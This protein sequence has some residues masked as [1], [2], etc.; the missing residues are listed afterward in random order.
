M[1]INESNNSL[2]GSFRSITVEN[3]SFLLC[4]ETPDDRR[5]TALY[6]LSETIHALDS[7]TGKHNASTYRRNGSG[8]HGSFKPDAGRS[9]EPAG[10]CVTWGADVCVAVIVECVASPPLSRE[11]HCDL[12]VVLRPEM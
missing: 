6:A 9:V 4:R 8:D 11:W 1:S 7:V 10:I 3:K 12:A 5:R 2:L